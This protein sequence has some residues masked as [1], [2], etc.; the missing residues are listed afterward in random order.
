[1]ATQM[2]DRIETVDSINQFP[3]ALFGY[4]HFRLSAYIRRSI[5]CK[6]LSV[7][8]I[9]ND[10]KCNIL[11]LLNKV[12]VFYCVE[13]LS[14]DKLREVQKALLPFLFTNIPPLGRRTGL[15]YLLFWIGLQKSRYV[16]L[17]AQ[18]A[19]CTYPRCAIEGFEDL[20]V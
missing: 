12:I 14:G 13:R 5:Y 15:L 9:F 8:N 17:I 1:M 3:L 4:G 16:L 20:N 18:I 19:Y 11:T 6:L 10:F 2:H 7:I